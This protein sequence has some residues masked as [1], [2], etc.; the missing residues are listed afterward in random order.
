MKGQYTIHYT[1]IMATMAL[2]ILPRDRV[3]HLLQAHHEGNGGG[4]CQKGTKQYTGW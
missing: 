4:G 3:L 1:K 2:A